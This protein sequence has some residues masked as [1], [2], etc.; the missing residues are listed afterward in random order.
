MRIVQRVLLLVLM[1]VSAAAF[2]FERKLPAKW[3]DAGTNFI[4]G[5]Y[6]GPNGWPTAP[7]FTVSYD[8]GYTIQVNGWKYLT[9]ELTLARAV[10]FGNSQFN[11]TPTCATPVQWSALA[12]SV[13][14]YLSWGFATCRFIGAATYKG[15]PSKGCYGTDGAPVVLEK[16]LMMTKSCE[17]SN[18]A[19]GGLV[20]DGE[21]RECVCSRG[22][23]VPEKNTCAPVVDRVVMLPCDYCKGNPIFPVLG[24][25]VQAVTV[26]WQPWLP[27][28]LTYNSIRKIPY[29]TA[30]ETPYMRS[31]S[32][33][34]GSTWIHSIDRQVL[35]DNPA[36]ARIVNVMR[37]N[38]MWTTFTRD[39][40]G[41]YLPATAA[42][43]DSL[44]PASDGSFLYYDRAAMLIERHSLTG[45]LLEISHIGGAK[46]GVTYSDPSTLS[47]TVR[48]IGLPLTLTDHFN[49]VWR[50]EYESRDERAPARVN[51]IVDPGL[52][53]VDIQ[54][55]SADQVQRLTWND[56]S[57]QQFLYE[58]PSF[59]WAL[60]GYLDENGARAGTYG[61]DAG[62]RA[63]STERALGLDG[64]RVTW[65]KP[66]QWT[67]AEHWD[68][69]LSLV[70][71]DH[72]L[73]LAEDVVIT[74]PNGT[75]EAVTGASVFGY[76]K[77]TS[78]SQV[79]GAGNAAATTR[80]VVDAN[81]NV[82]QIDDVNGN[83]SCMSYDTS[84]NLET[85][86]V[87]GLTTAT[88]CA[89]VSNAVPAGS[90]KVST[91]WHPD[92]PL[93]VKTAEPRRITTQVYNGQPDPFNANAV[94]S[95]APADAKLPD[96]KPIVV[97][98]KRVEQATTDEAGGQGFN[99]VLQSGVPARATRWTYNATGQVLTETDSRGK[100]ITTNA[101]Y[102]DTT[103]DHTIGDLKST[104]N[105][106][107]H[108]TTFPR[109]NAY[110][111]PLEMV[112]ANGTSTS[113]AY[114]LR[115]RLTS[116]TTAGKVTSYEYWPTGLL[117]KSTQPDGSAVSYEYD[118]AH[119]LIAV[120]DTLG[121]RIAYALDASGNRTKEDA[122]DPQGAL[123]RSMNRAFDALGRA[124]QAT[125]RE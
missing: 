102:T 104:I 25:K 21:T 31:E 34:F 86:R 56:G 72:T 11:A 32:Q 1:V 71:R 105:A 99:A 73:H 70:V 103:T 14:A 54:Y 12:C 48:D 100:V 87:E 19:Q 33:V 88:E 28:Q 40:S 109:Y 60:T 92:W 42:T 64:Y 97:L 66:S 84:R 36:D 108:V 41:R 107:G 7:G 111:Q 4:G 45:R 17:F 65:S 58:N 68:D 39:A 118:D 35:V 67:A 37:G 43:A 52:G 123:K 46:L 110:G 47:A 30:A 3:G 75:S 6:D 113:Y 49:R 8:G 121:D 20:F 62:G 63:I 10:A 22:V 23:A 76:A 125:G 61:Y 96:G 93:A 112:D 24:A 16:V 94:A 44:V 85:A 119:R 2:G 74:L 95:C 59:S 79:A 83:R 50:Y 116:T 57:N 120:S 5:S 13:E 77:W 82:T 89:A 78:R 55:G 114:D 69:V 80:R 26:G 18:G 90:R 53:R 15:D 98:C 9:P 29:Q 101:Y 115:Q 81:Q 91:Q 106:A 51:A 27:M 117:K 38:G 124:Q 122:K